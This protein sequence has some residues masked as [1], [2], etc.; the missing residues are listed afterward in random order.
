MKKVMHTATELRRF[1]EFLKVRRSFHV[2]F[3]IEFI[4]KFM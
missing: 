4:L 3:M 1:Y 2:K